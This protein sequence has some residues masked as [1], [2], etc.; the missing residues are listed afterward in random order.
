[1]T[2]KSQNDRSVDAERDYAQRKNAERKQHELERQ[3][4]KSRRAEEERWKRGWE[5]LES[6]LAEW[7]S[8]CNP[9]TVNKVANAVVNLTHDIRELG[10][11]KHTR[12]AVNRLDLLHERDPTGKSND[13]IDLPEVRIICRWILCVL[14]GAKPHGASYAAFLTSVSLTYSGRIG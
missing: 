8:E 12:I 1:M 4:A 7:A 9:E 3:L 10:F 11:E 6:A 5:S 2:G 13:L 14:D